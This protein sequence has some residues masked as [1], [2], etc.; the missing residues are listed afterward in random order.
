MSAQ[1]QQ[2]LRA[3]FDAYD[4]DKS[5]RIE[6]DEFLTLCEELQVSKKEADRIF[7]R[8]DVDSDGTVTLPEFLSGFQGRYGEDMEPDG[9]GEVSAAWENFEMR[10]GEQAKFIPR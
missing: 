7:N 5:G 6:R 2:R 1:E 4:A 8:L 10:L 3:L 9:G